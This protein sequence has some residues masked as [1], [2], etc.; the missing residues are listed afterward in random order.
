MD[1]DLL[2]IIINIEFIVFFFVIISALFHF[3]F[4]NRTLLLS[5]FISLCFCLYYHWGSPCISILC[6][7][8]YPWQYVYITFEYRKVS[9]HVHGGYC[10]VTSGQTSAATSGVRL[11]LDS[12][13]M[14]A[15]VSSVLPSSSD[16][17]G[18]ENRDVKE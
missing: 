13:S 11:R 5:Y 8:V 15:A 3:L 12:A 17:D 9:V 10:H 18:G 4:F 7:L 1:R 14:A 16:L 6:Y 2:V